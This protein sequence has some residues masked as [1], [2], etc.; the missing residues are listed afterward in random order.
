[1]ESPAQKNFLFDVLLPR[2]EWLAWLL[3][4]TGVALAYFA[5]PRANIFLFFGFSTLAAVY[6]LSSSAPSAKATTWPDQIEYKPIV[7]AEK[8]FL[9]HALIPYIQGIAMAVTLIGIQFKLLFLP[10]Y[11]TLLV[12]G[13]SIMATSTAI[14][15]AT[16]TLQRKLLVISALGAAV[17]Y[18][19]L[20]S[21]VRQFYQHDPVLAEK[22]IYHLQHPKD[23]AAAEEVRRL[24]K[25]R[26][27]H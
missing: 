14:Q 7:S 12:V 25:A 6:F 11:S 24:Q 26:Q 23:K 21:L 22:M 4:S 15:L 1:M 13:L 17:A 18:A 9:T 2:V 27:A 3:A 10:G 8:S 16:N 19:P 5:V 20:D